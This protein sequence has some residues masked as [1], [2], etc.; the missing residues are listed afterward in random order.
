MN[1]EKHLKTPLYDALCS[2]AK[3][4]I[5][6]FDVPG[7][8]KRLPLGG[9]YSSELMKHDANSTKELDMLSNPTG[10]IAEAEELI[11]DA[12]N[13]DYAFML[14]NGSTFGVIAMIMAACGPRDKIIMPRN[15]H[16]SAINGVILSGATPIFIDPE[17]DY[18]YGI[19][20]GITYESVKKAIKEHPEAKALFIIN[21]T[22]FGAVSDLKA[23][24]A[25]CK[26]KHIA[27]LADE[28]HGAHLPFYSEFPDSAIEMGADLST[29]SIHK[30][31]GALTQ[32]SVL[33][34]NERYFKYH[35]IKTVI[36]LMQTTSASYILMSSLDLA[37]KRLVFEGEKIFSE[38]YTILEDAKNKINKIPGLSCLTRDNI[39]GRGIHD[40]DETKI[41][42][43]VNDLGFSGFEIYDLLKKE[44]GI[45]T[46]LA[47]TYCILA[48]V[49]IG[50]NKETIDRLV[51]ALEDISRKFYGKRKRFSVKMTDFFEKPKTVISPR[52][53]YYAPKKVVPIDESE[54]EICGEPLMIYPPGIPLIIPGERINKKIIEHYWFY[55]DQNCVVMNDQEEIGQIK[56]LGE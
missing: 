42:I 21:P 37:R 50:D 15:V 51:S 54:G 13:A 39:N 34:L 33:L 12:Y 9:I 52:E 38:L 28:A 32:T 41:V 53:A 7:H 44:Y 20:N 4:E 16:K 48:V 24:I 23:I 14:V 40:Y 43:K 27:V 46:E 2:Y 31:C 47:E 18:E 11:A 19:A 6:H 49:G 29:V 55:V 10:V 45:Q 25:L 17:I 30:T 3:Q 1:R 56:I 36:N 22:Y 26:R 8:K 5:I 35:Q